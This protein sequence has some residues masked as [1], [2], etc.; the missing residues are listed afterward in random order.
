M[1]KTLNQLLLKNKILSIVTSKKKSN[2]KILIKKL[3]INFFSVNCP[4]YKHKGKPN[5]DSLIYCIKK[6]KINKNKLDVSYR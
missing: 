2:V 4:N 1:K 3:G 6:S 5:P